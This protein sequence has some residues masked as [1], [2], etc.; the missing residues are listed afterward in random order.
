[1]KMYKRNVVTISLLVLVTAVI[2]FLFFRNKENPTIQNMGIE[3]PFIS[4]VRNSKKIRGVIVAAHIVDIKPQLSGVLEKIYVTVGEQVQKNQPIAKIKVVPSLDEVSSAQKEFRVN[5]I[6][7]EL[8]K[9]MLD[10]HSGVYNLG[11]ISK[12]KLEEIEA[13]MKISKLNYE[14]SMKKLEMLLNSTVRGA[15][16][17]DFTIVHSTQSGMVLEI[18]FQHGSRVVKS[19]SNTDGTCIASIANMDSLIFKSE[20]NESDI[21]KIHVGMKLSLVISSMDS[22]KV[23]AVISE[24]SPQSLN[25]N[26]VNKFKFLARLDAR[27]YNLPYSGITATADILFA[28][29]DSV[30]CIKEKFLQFDHGKPYVEV[31]C[32]EERVKHKVETGLSD[33]FNIEIKNG[34]SLHEKL[35]L[36]DWSKN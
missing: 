21:A 17:E 12:T 9:K 32:D 23:A 27:D 26:G 20:I 29:T 30:L 36:P 16:N 22:V 33:G 2:V 11:G 25:E 35:L 14:S 10:D 5:R 6:Q 28:E 7:Y 19:T 4:V 15:D 3:K 31:W 24:I 8:D 34:L 1:M 18:P 13:N